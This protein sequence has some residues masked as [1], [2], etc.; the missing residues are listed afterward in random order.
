MQVICHLLDVH[1]VQAGASNDR[2]IHQLGDERVP[3]ADQRELRWM[4]PD[5]FGHGCHVVYGSGFTVGLQYPGVGD[6]SLS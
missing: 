1:R 3:V 5:P 4:K 6:K 2:T